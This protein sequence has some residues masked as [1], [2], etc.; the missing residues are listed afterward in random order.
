MTAEVA[1][2]N[3]EAVAMAADS[4]ATMSNSRGQKIS[5]SANKIFALSRSH[6]VGI[7]IYGNASFMEVPWETII[8]LYRKKLVNTCF[9][10][11]AEYAEDFI[12]FL[13]NDDAL[14]PKKIQD[15]HVKAVIR[16]FYDKL[17]E[18]ITEE[19]KKQLSADQEITEK[20]IKNITHSFIKENFDFWKQG[21]HTEGFDKKARTTFYNEYKKFIEKTKKE[22]FDKLPY[23]STHSKYLSETAVNMFFIFPRGIKMPGTSGLV[24]S[25]FGEKEI[26]PAL[27]SLSVERKAL[28]K[29]KYKFDYD[30]QI[31]FEEPAVITPFA[32]TEMVST[33]IEGIHPKYESVMLKLIEDTIK[34]Y[35]KIVLDSIDGL[36]DE[37][38]EKVERSINDLSMGE[39]KNF[40]NKLQDYKNQNFVREILTVVEFL[41]KNELAEMAEALVNL[42]CL[43][44]KITMDA[45][46]VGGP[47][48]VAVISK[49]DGLIWIRRKHYFEPEMNPHYIPNKYLKT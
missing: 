14:I 8:K 41:P 5:S 38:R 46:T 35:P 27:T 7:M 6:P 21:Q 37:Q 13:E 30:Y 3:K 24:F 48:D 1:I 22:I 19:I 16:A 36:T 43:K 17:F 11:I 29:L 31:S 18:E 34:D 12:S 26:F 28:G 40:L 44:K 23:S 49:G 4:A 20:E 47:I 25:G 33:F 2:M 42:T 9:D 39:T 45:E 10:T 15:E 32:Q